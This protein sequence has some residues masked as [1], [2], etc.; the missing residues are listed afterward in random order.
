[1]LILLFLALHNSI[2]SLGWFPGRSYMT[3][4][5]APKK[6]ILHMGEG[7]QP[8]EMS[9]DVECDELYVT[10]G[11][12]GRDNSMALKGLGREPRCRELKRRGRGTWSEDKPPI[13]ILVEGGVVR[14]MCHQ[15]V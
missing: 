4:F 5:R 12:K 2:L 8:V 10:T 14:I 3:M 9:G 7:V 15:V 13:F 1:M 6:L 11:L